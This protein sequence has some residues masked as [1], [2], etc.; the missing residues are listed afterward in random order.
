MSLDIM[1]RYF[2]PSELLHRSQSFSHPDFSPISHFGISFLSAPLI[3]ENQIATKFHTEHR[4]FRLPMRGHR[5]FLLRT[6]SKAS[7]RTLKPALRLELYC[8]K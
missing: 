7:L 3:T 4:A 2:L 5:Y 1:R 6:F 8:L